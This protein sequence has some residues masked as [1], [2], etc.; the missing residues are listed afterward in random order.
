MIV[1]LMNTHRVGYLA[2]EMVET[3]QRKQQELGITDVDVL[4]VKLA[5]LCHDLG[6]FIITLP[7]VLCTL[8]RIYIL[9]PVLCLS[10]LGHG[11]FSHLFD[12]K[13]IPKVLPNNKWKVCVSTSMQKLII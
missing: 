4:C 7:T 5:G 6:Q 12:G 11:P 2:G 8:Y 13:F 9:F 1:E 3:L 10:L